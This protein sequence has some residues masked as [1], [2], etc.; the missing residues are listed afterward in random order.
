MTSEQA[1]HIGGAV[2]IAIGLGSVPLLFVVL[3]IK[4]RRAT[5]RRNM[6]RRQQWRR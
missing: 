1:D 4:D 6:A 5:V 3:W 2:M